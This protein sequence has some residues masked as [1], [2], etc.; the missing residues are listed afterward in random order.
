MTHAAFGKCL[1]PAVFGANPSAAAQYMLEC[2]TDHHKGRDWMELQQEV[3][4][5][6]MALCFLESTQ[7]AGASVDEFLEWLSLYGKRAGEDTDKTAL[8][9]MQFVTIGQ[10][11]DMMGH[12]MRYDEY[13]QVEAAVS[14][15]LLSMLAAR[16][17]A[18][19]RPRRSRHPPHMARHS[20]WQIAFNPVTDFRTVGPTSSVAAK[21][22][23]RPNCTNRT[24]TQYILYA[25]PW[26]TGGTSMAPS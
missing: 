5:V 7:N 10:H 8:L 20:V 25:G 19:C 22:T 9:L 15:N 4:E 16:G 6:E 2:D 14:G 1:T 24:Q 11:L 21:P 23:P 17:M 18:L 26:P 3:V 12:G 13:D